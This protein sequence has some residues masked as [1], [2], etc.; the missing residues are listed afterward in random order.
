MA[1]RRKTH[2]GV[3]RMSTKELPGSERP[4]YGLLGGGGGRLWTGGAMGKRCMREDCTLKFSP[5]IYAR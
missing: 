5:D 3:K 4:W 1:M 2:R